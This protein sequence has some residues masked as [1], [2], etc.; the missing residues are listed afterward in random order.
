MTTNAPGDLHFWLTEWNWQPSIIGGTILIMALYL[1]AVG[2]LRKKFH[3]ADEFPL[4]RTLVF[5]LGLYLMFLSLFSAL[6]ELGDRYLFSAHMVQ[7]LILSLVGPPLLLLGMPD[8]LVQPLL[9]NRVLLSIGKALTHPAVAFTLFNA[10]LWLWHAPPLY[11][12][13]LFNQNLHILEHLTFV[14]FGLLYWWP[15]FSPVQEGL[16]CLSMGGQVLY[17]FF[18]SMPMVLLGAGLTFTPPLYTPYISAPRVWGLS[19]AV[20]QQLGGLLMWIPV[21]LYIIVIM[22]IV[23]IRWMQQQE[24]LQHDEEIRRDALNDTSDTGQPIPMQP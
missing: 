5:L 14:F 17:L 2:P 12:A 16:P 9:R 20:D 22:S 19:A 3:L 10:D 24:R 11:D 18:G 21:S 13:T 15:I 8:W 23:F 7:H 4:G 6:D 1:Y